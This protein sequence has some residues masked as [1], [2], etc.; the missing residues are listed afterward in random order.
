MG[1]AITVFHDRPRLLLLYFVLGLILIVQGIATAFWF[2]VADDSE[3]ELRTVAVGL[4]LFVTWLG[5][6]FAGTARR[7]MRDPE[8]PIVIGPAGLH[9]RALTVRPIPWTD[10]RNLRLSQYGKGGPVVV[11][12]L[13]EGAAERAGMPGRVRWTAAV[14]RPF[15]YDFH[16]HG[17]GTDASPERLAE[18]IAPY[19][20]V[21]RR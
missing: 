13:A 17:M 4:A 9:D 12:D 3:M 6:W 16:I 14:N 19:A 7:R 10:V 15:G 20:E 21:K 1:P 11:F 5:T 18:A 8:D 2:L